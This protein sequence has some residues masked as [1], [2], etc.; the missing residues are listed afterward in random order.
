MV[1][2]LAVFFLGV[3]LLANQYR[4][5]PTSEETVHSLLGRHVFGDGPL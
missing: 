2:I 5:L 4:V 1:A 3:S